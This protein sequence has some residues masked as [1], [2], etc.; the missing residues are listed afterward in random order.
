MK[1]CV[2]EFT[3]QSA[4]DCGCEWGSVLVNRGHHPTETGCL[5]FQRHLK[6]S[7]N[8]KQGITAKHAA[9]EWLR[10]TWWSH[11]IHRLRVIYNLHLQ[12]TNLQNCSCMKRSTNLLTTLRH[13]R[14]VQ[15]SNVFL[16]KSTSFSYWP[17][18]NDF[19]QLYIKWTVYYLCLPLI[20]IEKNNEMLI[21][22]KML[23]FTRWQGQHRYLRI[24]WNASYIKY[25]AGMWFQ[26]K[27]KDQS[28]C[29]CVKKRG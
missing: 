16:T 28:G 25:A 4:V 6:R 7:A 9:T 26:T 24:V 15:T 21:N 11:V 10:D 19:T 2:G 8:T 29:V 27:M 12:P 20:C 3:H 5:L 17:D 14:S 23:P 1:D 18:K 22:L 13:Q